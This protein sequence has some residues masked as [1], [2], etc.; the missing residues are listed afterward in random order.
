MSS[1]AGTS[2][3]SGRGGRTQS[4]S[5]WRTLVSGE[6]RVMSSA[7]GTMPRKSVA[8]T[9]GSIGRPVR[10]GMLRKS[11]PAGRATR[12]KVRRGRATSV[13]PCV[14]TVLVVVM[15]RAWRRRLG[16]LLGSCWT[17]DVGQGRAFR[18]RS[19]RSTTS[20]RYGPG[21]TRARRNVSRASSNSAVCRVDVAQQEQH[22]RVRAMS[23][24]SKHLVEAT[25]KPVDGVGVGT[26][27]QRLGPVV[28]ALGQRCEPGEAE[29]V[30]QLQC[31]G[32]QVAEVLQI[33]RCT[34]RSR[35][36]ASGRPPEGMACRRRRRVRRLHRWPSA[37]RWCRRCRPLQ[38]ASMR[39]SITWRFSS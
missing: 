12:A 29:P 21:C 11:Q 25:L 16:G 20:P 5:S 23:A 15:H 32:G 8:S 7:T 9:K 18:R 1:R 37:G 34:R 31:L 28:D 22:R 26:P 19:T 39:Q 14:A 3:S 10:S 24:S 13:G 6:R 36:R 2:H 33:R 4:R 17:T 27:R 35:H 30:V 38:Y